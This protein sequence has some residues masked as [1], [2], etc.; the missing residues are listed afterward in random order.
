[1]N[2]TIYLLALVFLS[3]TYFCNKT[4]AQ[5]KF[6]NTSWSEIK[7]KAKAENKLVFLDAYTTWCS[8]CKWMAKNVFTNDTVAEYYNSIFV[9]AKIDME[10]GEGID[11]S[12][13]YTITVYPTLLFIDGNGEVI[14][15]SVGAKNTNDFIQ[16]GK[17]AQIPEKQFGILDKRYKSGERDSKFIET[18]LS[19]LR[20]LY[21]N[22][23]APL[24]EYFKT[25]KEEDLLSRDNWN[26]MYNFLSDYKTREFNYLLKN[27]DAFA[28]KYTIDSVNNKMYNVFIDKCYNYIYAKNVD[29]TKYLPFK[30][31]IKK[32]NFARK[33]ELILDADM[34]YFE[35]KKDYDNY[36]KVA[37]DY[38]DKYQSNNEG[39]LNNI[40]YRFYE[41]VKDKTM[42]TKAEEWAKKAY[43]L[44]PHPSFNMDTYACLLFVNGKKDEAIKLE[45]DAIELI[46]SDKIK[47]DQQTIEDMEKK[48]LEWSK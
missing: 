15:R 31:E 7:A 9:N 27:S 17:D 2:K 1:M 40:S 34:S 24:A 19:A 44:N 33:E 6:E 26:L 41:V 20:T 10:A 25:Q 43:E 29:S 5:I 14:H 42:L 37:S 48:I 30:E 18:Y 45:R 21:L 4:F 16:L 46:K 38:I 13:Q 3:T 35:K 8:P 32:L 39:I 28:K 12:K 47:Y 22:T 11:I 23:N 36:A